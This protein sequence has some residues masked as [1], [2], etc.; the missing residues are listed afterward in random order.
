MRGHI[1]K[2]S[3]N[4]WAVVVELPRDPETGKRRQK[5]VTVRGP[6]REAE[7]V[8]SEMLADLGRGLMGT[9]PRNLTLGQYLDEWLEAVRD[10][11]RPQTLRVWR[12]HL[13]H[14]KETL[15]RVPLADLSALDVQRALGELS[16]RLSDRS[17]RTVFTVLRAACRQAVKWGLIGRC[18]TD[19]VKLPAA[20]P[21]QMGVWDEEQ[22][23]RFLDAAQ[24]T[25]CY[26]LFHVA[27]TTGMRLGELLG[28]TWDDVDLNRGEI[29]VR[30]SLFLPVRGE[31]VW[32]DP[33][34]PGSRRKI[35]IDG[36]TARVLWQWKKRQAEERLRAGPGWHD[37]N[38]V[39]A[40][41][42][43]RPLDSSYVAKVLKSAA[44]RAGVQPL[45]FHDLRHTH[46]T[47]LFR[48]GV[49]PKVVSERLGH[50][51]V[52]LTL[53][54]YSHLLPDT[55]REAVRAVERALGQRPGDTRG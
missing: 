42:R 36:G 12:S 50:S 52:A 29:L 3:K 47:L 32:Q 26:T 10:S 25:R 40:T 11:V 15:G 37:Y 51:S 16:S 33:K 45:R 14:W 35:P 23:V 48:Q 27:L 54:T 22:V 21:R 2:R 6:K 24:G 20:G 19:A 44:A 18:P 5:W 41:A 46:A 38:L 8:R 28:L 39:F 49:H 55:Q 1:R 9:A 31:P 43:G 53:D 4:S 34:T 7:R 13:K 30:R 17:R